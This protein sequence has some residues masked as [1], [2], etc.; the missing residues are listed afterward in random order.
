[1]CI[2]LLIALLTL[3]KTAAAA[4]SSL[5]PPISKADTAEI[6]QVLSTVTRKP[7]LV[8]IAATREK[9]FAGAVVRYDYLVDVRSGKQTPIPQYLRRDM[10][11]VYMRYTDRFHVDVYRVR[12]VRGHWRIEEKSDGFL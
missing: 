6:T 4:D 8:M 7:I 10:V 9:P 3:L 11:Y 5:E 2:A 1:M 12:K